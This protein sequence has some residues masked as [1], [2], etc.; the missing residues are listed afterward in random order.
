[1]RILITGGA[2]FQGSHLTERCLST[3]HQVTILNTFSDYAVHSIGHLAKD[4]SIVWGSITD[5][6]IVEKTVRGQELVV[7][8]AARIN[9]DESIEA[10]SSF[11]AANIMGTYNVLEAVRKYSCRL[12][13]ASSC[14]VYGT[15]QRVVSENSELRPHS[16]YA[17]SKAAADRLCFAYCQT[18]GVD[19]VIVRPS[20]VYGPRQKGGKGGAVIPIFVQ[21]ALEHRPL[22]VFGTGEQRREYI[23]VED[24]VRG[25][26]LVIGR[27]DLQGEVVNFGTADTPSIKE[28][29]EFISQQFDTSVEFLPA[30]LGEVQG[31]NL[32][33]SKATQLG[34][35]PQVPFWDGLDSYIRW[36]KSEQDFA[37]D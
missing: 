2:G 17:A 22:T 35:V 28:I 23:H 13:Y 36:R 11:L 1:M 29:A 3:G 26:E 19:V 33:S 15:H 24:I 31:F 21:R 10:P 20:N 25:Y 9:V 4:V 14:E 6:E 18:Y 7:H 12:V 32:D 30:R 27:T 37:I 8:M 16:P 34:F 5:P